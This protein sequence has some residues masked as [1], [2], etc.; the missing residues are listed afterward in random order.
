MNGYQGVTFLE[1]MATLSIAAV[2]ALLSTVLF[3]DF[4]ARYRLSATADSLYFQLQ[5][6]RSEAVKRNIPVYVSF[7]AGDTWCYGIHTSSACDCTTP[8]SCSLG[9]VSYTK[10]G[11]IS[12][13]TNGLISNAIY[14]DGTNGS[15]N[16]SG[17]ITFTKYG[18][19]TP[20]ITTPLRRLG[21]TTA[22]ST[23]VNGYSAC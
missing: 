20:L 1:M 9:T 18:Q 10:A 19:S 11:L 17:S 12:L 3:T 7:H 21:N 16:A 2:L 23:D 5:Y 15:A 13:S 4:I 14:F 22:C 8:A 6:A